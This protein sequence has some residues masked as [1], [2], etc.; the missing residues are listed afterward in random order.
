MQEAQANTVTGF[1]GFMARCRAAEWA[2]AKH[3][4]FG[5]GDAN[6]S[7]PRSP[8]PLRSPQGNTMQLL[9][10]MPVC[11]AAQPALSQN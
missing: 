10:R 9:C 7:L 11:C 4:M 5:L 8:N 6:G 2:A 3:D 1:E